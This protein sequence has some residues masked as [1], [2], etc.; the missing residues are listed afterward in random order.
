MKTRYLKL[1]LSKISDP[2]LLEL[3]NEIGRPAFISITKMCLMALVSP[4]E[5]SEEKLNTYLNQRK[6]S[7]VKYK[8]NTIT[9]VFQSDKYTPLFKLLDSRTK[10]F[11]ISGFVKLILR[12][13]LFLHLA[14]YYFKDNPIL[15]LDKEVLPILRTAKI[16][17]KTVASR[18]SKTISYKATKEITFAKPI[19]KKD[20]PLD[21][22]PKVEVLKPVEALPIEETPTL[23]ITDDDADEFDA[24]AIL[25]QLI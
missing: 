10:G 7:D 5:F 21:T 16:K 9:I 2:D 11:T 24:L 3:L 15:L 6:P 17:V 13:H 4:T 25:D 18:G 12:Q 19:T 8:N 1:Y 23:P 20:K 22:T 14:N